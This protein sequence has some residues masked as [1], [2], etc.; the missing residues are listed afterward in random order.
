MT[1]IDERTS[2]LFATPLQAVGLLGQEAHPPE[3]RLQWRRPVVPATWKYALP[4][5]RRHEQQ[6]CSS[7]RSLALREIEYDQDRVRPRSTRPAAALSPLVSETA[8]TVTYIVYVERAGQLSGAVR[9]SAA[10]STPLTSLGGCC[11]PD[12][13]GPWRFVIDAAVFKL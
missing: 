13:V 12:A 8:A 9:R 7:R 5:V 10:G 2:T 3:V 1:C 6:P 4:A 11:R